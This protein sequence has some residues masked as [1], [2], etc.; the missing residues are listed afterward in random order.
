M[1]SHTYTHRVFHDPDLDI[2][3]EFNSPGPLSLDHPYTAIFRREEL[4]LFFPENTWDLVSVSHEAIH[5]AYW[6]VYRHLSS[7]FA[8]QAEWLARLVPESDVSWEHGYPR[9]QEEA[10]CKLHDSL[11]R[12]AISELEEQDIY[13]K[14]SAPRIRLRGGGA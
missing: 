8:E 14:V 4:G 11:V 6:V 12:R 7:P 9:V 13:Y 5:A 10:V 1:S 3:V 2:R